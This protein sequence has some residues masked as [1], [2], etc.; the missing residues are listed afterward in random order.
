MPQDDK[1]V[2]IV[3]E[4]G[5]RHYFPPGFDPKTAGRY[6][7]ENR[8]PPTRLGSAKTGTIGRGVDAGLAREVGGYDLGEFASGAAENFNPMNAV[9]ASQYL[10]TTDPR[11]SVP[12]MVSGTAK[13]LGDVISGDS[14]AT[15]RLAGSLMTGPVLKGAAGVMRNTAAPWMMDMA[16][17]RTPAVRR[18]FPGAAQQLIDDAIIPVGAT[19]TR[20][21]MGAPVQPGNI[22]RALE[23]TEGQ[24]TGKAKLLDAQ[25]RPQP[26]SLSLGPQ[27]APS[28]AFRTDPDTM[29]AQALASAE[30][31]GR[32]P[33]L[34]NVPGPE[35]AELDALAQ[36][37]LDR[38]TRTRG[39]E[40]T[41]DQKRAYQGRTTYN[42]RVNAPV[43]TN[44]ER[45][46]NAGLAEANRAEAIRQAPELEGLLTKEQNLLGALE[47]QSNRDVASAPASVVNATKALL[48]LKNPTVMASGA[49]LTDRL[50]KAVQGA[51][52]MS[53]PANLIRLLIGED[54][55][56]ELKALEEAKKKRR[57]EPSDRDTELWRGPIRRDAGGW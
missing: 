2:I 6:V 25:G 55:A 47:A 21:V 41:I 52:G 46:F 1:P 36:R 22:L 45:N 48:G 28:L 43:Q 14:K 4:Q 26:P 33:G 39:L 57:V 24:V 17:G 7:R 3:D 20:A 23:E 13:E 12:Q 29:A 40:E 11:E 32:I 35:S 31:K 10:L 56:A 44:E 8:E 34:G 53:L 51:A 16:L 9:R 54:T 19:D 15:G 18:N 27:Q 38:N 49:I 30:E 50:G 42:N 5:K 37:Y